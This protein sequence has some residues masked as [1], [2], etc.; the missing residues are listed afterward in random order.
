MLISLQFCY[1]YFC[2]S[3][4]IP[5]LVSPLYFSIF[6]L[7]T[8]SSTLL[9]HPFDVN[10]YAPSHSYPILLS[11]RSRTCVVFIGK[12]I[13]T[14]IMAYYRIA[15]LCYRCCCCCL[16]FWFQPSLFLTANPQPMFLLLRRRHP[17]QWHSS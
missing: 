8:S 2:F 17:I 12:K 16:V 1:L 3:F 14:P 10:P 4:T 13:T 9:L 11:L 5:F 7:S 6:P 15:P